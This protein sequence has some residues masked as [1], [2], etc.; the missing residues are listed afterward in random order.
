M[1][2]L[3]AYGIDP[4]GKQAVVVGRSMVIGKP[5]AM[6][7]LKKNATVTICHTRTEDLAAT[8]RA[9]QIL[10]AAAGKPKMITGDMVGEGAVVVDVGIN[11]DEAGNLCGDVDFEEAK[12]KA[13]SI[14]PVPKGV[15][16]VTTSVLAAHVLRSAGYLQRKEENWDETNDDDLPSGLWRRAGH[17][18]RRDCLSVC[19]AAGGGKRAL[20]GGALRHCAERSLSVYW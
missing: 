4:T 18:Y 11:V 20:R 9:A 13:D 12:E 8:C 5:A 2:M 17:F 7:L 16:S 10:V 15:G 19:G 3:D 14:T 1:T 6:L